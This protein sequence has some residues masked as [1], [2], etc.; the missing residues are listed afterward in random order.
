MSIEYQGKFGS[1]IVF[2]DLVEESAAS[3]IIA[4]MNHPISE[5]AHVRV[6]P[7]VH[8]GAGC[9]IGYTAKLT[10][11]V[12]PNLI[13]VDIGCGMLSFKLGLRTEIGEDFNKLDL[14]IRR[15]VPSGRD[16]RNKEYKDLDSIFAK[17]VAPG[18]IFDNFAFFS[19]CV[20]AI[21]KVQGQNFDRAIKSIGTLGGGNHFIE[22][23]EDADGYLWLTIHSGSRNLG[24]RIAEYHQKIAENKI[25][26]PD[27]DEFKRQVEII[28]LTKHGKGIEQA[29]EAL[30][31][32]MSKRGKRSGLEYL[33]YSD[34]DAYVHDMDVAQ[35]YARLNRMV[36][37]YEIVHYFYKL[38][39][40]K[41]EMIESI[42][43]YINF[44]DK[45][46]RKGA[47]SA[48]EG[49]RVIIPF[50]MADGLIIGKGKGNED[51]NNSAPHGAGRMMSRSEAK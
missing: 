34:K 3:Q 12:V 17:K 5:D 30:R 18:S 37:A 23:G 19:S 1:A 41:T 49:E 48:H 15:G 42:H 26:G 4:L 22:L 35:T 28:K 8:A 31:T 32:G 50:N 16:V 45:V 6:M 10:D 29:I 13:G 9:V 51:W 43:N 2:N 46:V 38:D 39:F 44:Q 47:I 27:E 24:K 33:E 14:E 11:K 21:C 7:D 20:Q 36:M 25:L 40:F